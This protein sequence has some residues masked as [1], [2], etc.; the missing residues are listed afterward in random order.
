MS[1]TQVFAAGQPIGNACPQNSQ[2][3]NLCKLTAGN[4]G[5]IISSFVTFA[6][7]IIALIALLFLVWGGVKWLMSQGDKNEVEGARNHIINAIIGLIVIF[8]SY[9]IVNVLLSFLT[10]GQVSLSNL[11][12]PTL[13]Q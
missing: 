6:F 2:F 1:A 5:N 12:L 8:F 10:G 13:G 7:V 4:L 3:S 9:L 11:S